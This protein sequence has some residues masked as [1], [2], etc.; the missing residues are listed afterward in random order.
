MN[1]LINYLWFFLILFSVICAAATGRMPQLSA[2]VISGAG[3][4]VTLSIGMA[5]M[6]CAWTGLL[7]IAEKGGAS[8]Y[9]AKALRPV[10][11]RLFPI[12]PG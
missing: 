6:M 9:L 2:A 5:G 4:A 8:R 1:S 7:K 10:V 12:L 3:E 11:G